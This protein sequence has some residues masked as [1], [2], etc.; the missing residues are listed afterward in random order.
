MI[1]IVYPNVVIVSMP[2]ALMKHKLCKLFIERVG[3]TQ[4][5]PQNLKH[6]SRVKGINLGNIITLFI[7]L[8]LKSVKLRQSKIK[9]RK[10]AK[11]IA[12]VEDHNILEQVFST[13]EKI[14]L[15][16]SINPLL[17]FFFYNS[18]N[19]IHEIG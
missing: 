4:I 3:W 8:K 10:F 7:F 6:A 12:I 17:H 11:T 15:A 5:Q 16:R 1:F 18:V 9:M 13:C 2:F 14:D 19:K